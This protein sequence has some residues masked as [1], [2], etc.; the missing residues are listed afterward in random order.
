MRKWLLYLFSLMIIGI[1]ISFILV[2]Q[3]GYGPWDIFYS[4]L[5]DL[6]DTNFVVVHSIVSV[7]VVT[8]GFI[9]RKQKPDA[10]IIVITLAAA[11]MA[12]WVDVFRQLSTPENVWLGYLMLISGLM[13]IAI[14]VNIARF[15]QIILP[16]FEFFLQS[17]KMRTNLSFGR[18]KQ[19]SEVIVF[20]IGVSMGFIFDLEFKVWYGTLIII[21]GGGYFINLTYEPVKRILSNIIKE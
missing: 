14:G 7:I 18:I 13:F 15:T 4:N 11:F 8:A 12:F 3:V 2:A 20:I 10:Q 21:F 6:F 17:I 19:I 9:I 1:G 5:V 16:A